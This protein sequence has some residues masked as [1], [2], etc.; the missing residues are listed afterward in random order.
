MFTTGKNQSDPVGY[1]SHLNRDYGIP[2][3]ELDADNAPDILITKFKQEGCYFKVP[4]KFNVGDTCS[5]HPNLGL[6]I[7]LDDSDYDDVLLVE[8]LKESEKYQ[9]IAGYQV[10]VVYV[11]TDGNNYVLF[12]S[13]HYPPANGPTLVWYN[14]STGESHV[15]STKTVA[16]FH[17]ATKVIEK[18]VERVVYK[19]SPTNPVTAGVFAA[20]DYIIQ[21][22]L[23]RLAPSASN[24]AIMT[25]FGDIVKSNL[26]YLTPEDV[27]YFNSYT[28]VVFKGIKTPEGSA[29]SWELETTPDY[30]HVIA[31][32]YAKYGTHNQMSTDAQRLFSAGW[33]IGAASAYGSEL[34][35][36]KASATIKGYHEKCK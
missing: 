13:V 10:E 27:E 35:I 31:K 1:Q 9:R 8:S 30:D 23:A 14:A 34:T 7:E 15:V 28:R 21:L 19:A 33:H 26:G 17:P 29:E 5:W 24:L 22:T 16:F 11:S 3:T 12:K 6:P 2:H 25:M 4:T 36:A 32:A 20:V 18:P